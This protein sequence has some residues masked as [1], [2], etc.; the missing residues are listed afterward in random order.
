MEMEKK[1]THNKTKFHMN[2]NNELFFYLKLTP[3]TRAE[4]RCFRCHSRTTTGISV[5]RNGWLP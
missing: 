3:K 5:P 1:K 4:G 2:F